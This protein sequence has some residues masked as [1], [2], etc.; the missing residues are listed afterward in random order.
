MSFNPRAPRG[1]RQVVFD[2]RHRLVVFQSARPARGATGGFIALA[3]ESTVSIRAPREGR[4]L[5]RVWVVIRPA[6][7]IRAPR[8]GRDRQTVTV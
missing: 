4:D 3:A 2:S 1:A 6:V 7:S 5:G 8:E